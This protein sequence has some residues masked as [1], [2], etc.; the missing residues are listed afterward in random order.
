MARKLLY[1]FL[2]LLPA[3]AHVPLK[4]YPDDAYVELTLERAFVREHAHLTRLPITEA[5]DGGIY[6]D[7]WC[8][9]LA[10]NIVLA[11]PYVIERSL[12][13]IGGTDVQVY[14]LDHSEYKQGLKWGRN[15]IYIPP[16]IR[17]RDFTLVVEFS[18]TYVGRAY[19]IVKHGADEVPSI[20]PSGSGMQ[21]ADAAPTAD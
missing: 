12:K 3:C 14:P 7:T 19:I 9:C 16:E 1:V 2:A 17:N 15:R 18:G 6:A 11:V 8:E 5:I 20:Q 4:G 10:E 21:K 13:S